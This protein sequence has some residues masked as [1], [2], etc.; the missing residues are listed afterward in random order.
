LE[1]SFNKE[2][3]MSTTTLNDT[4]KRHDEQE[5]PRRKRVLIAI[6]DSMPSE[7]AVQYGGRLAEELGGRVMLLHVAEYP[8][9]LGRPCQ[10][11]CGWTQVVGNRVAARTKG[12]V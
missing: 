3:A 12:C 4:F 5:V 8:R 6:D 9:S 1:P 11:S 10:S 7:W 2:K